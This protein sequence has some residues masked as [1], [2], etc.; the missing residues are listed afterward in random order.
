MGI[1][2]PCLLL[3]IAAKVDLR[4]I[5]GVLLLSAAVVK[6]SELYLFGVGCRLL[7]SA[8]GMGSET[9]AAVGSLLEPVVGRYAPYGDSRTSLAS[10]GDLTF[11]FLFVILLILPVW[12]RCELCW[13]DV[14]I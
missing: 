8:G 4:E 9:D 2:L 14:L 13:E 11:L 6:S 3:V 10:S 7:Q 5:H 1:G 12:W